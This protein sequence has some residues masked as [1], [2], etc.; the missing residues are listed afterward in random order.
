MQDTCVMEDIKNP[1]GQSLI[2]F[3]ITKISAPD[4]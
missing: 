4:C 3:L 1:Q 2:A